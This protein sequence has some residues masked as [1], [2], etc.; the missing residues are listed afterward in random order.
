M[1]PFTFSDNV[2]NFS[3]PTSWEMLTQE[4]LRYV[5]Y[6]ITN[7]EGTKAKTYIFIRMLGI[8]V[9]RKIA[10]GWVCS[11]RSATGKKIWFYLN[12]WEIMA[13][14]KN[15]DFVDMPGQVPVCLFQIGDLKAVDVRL[16][17]V[18]FADYIKTENYYQGFLR[19]NDN[20]QLSAIAKILYVDKEGGSPSDISFSDA[21][22]LSV[23]LWIASVK[24]YF[25][26]CFPYFFSRTSST[27]DVADVPD[28]VAV[29]N[30]EIR[31]LTG[32][33]I[34]KENDVLS[35]DCWR[36]LTELNEKA[37]ETKEWNEK[38]GRK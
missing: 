8:K 30:A 17:G 1:I 27:G 32:G 21:E 3:L 24:N 10:S 18:S 16:R 22:L 6:A 37:R 7:F 34:T 26:A 19:T 35:M 15:L 13:F 23:F 12:K 11:V 38:Y 2:L 5:C 28:M 25:A 4:Q 29:M 14:L 36:A 20:R 31:A 9:Y 33:D